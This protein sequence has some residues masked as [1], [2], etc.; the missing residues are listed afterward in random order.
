MILHKLPENMV[1]QL[2]SNLNQRGVDC[3]YEEFN[4]VQDFWMKNLHAT[5]PEI[6][7]PNTALEYISK[8]TSMPRAKLGC[9]DSGLCLIGCPNSG[10]NSLDQN[11]YKE[12][13]SLGVDFY[14]DTHA[15]IG[16]DDNENI[17]VECLGVKSRVRFKLKPKYSIFLAA[18]PVNSPRVLSKLFPY[19]K[20]IGNNLRLNLGPSIALLYPSGVENY[21]K[22]KMGMEYFGDDG[23][24]FA[25]QSLPRELALARLWPFSL[26]PLSDF[27]ELSKISLWT[28]SIPSSGHGILDFKKSKSRIGKFFLTISDRDKILQSIRILQSIGQELGAL[29]DIPLFFN[30]NGSSAMTPSITSP[31]QINGLSL[32]SSHIFG[33][34]SKIGPFFWRDGVNY[35]KTDAS[36]I[37]EIICVDS[38]VI[39]FATGVNPI[40]T[41][42]STS[43][44][45][46]R[47]VIRSVVS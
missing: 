31:H 15:E 30:K 47:K 10:K 36:K 20:E 4:Q 37:P 32:G 45:I 1:N 38:S 21:E 17:L 22:M 12:L 26:N 33:T 43:T 14:F 28:S 46:S 2:I 42:L 35:V 18:G 23:V 7:Y 13:K 29:R 24:K 40:I 41:I 25:T 5:S 34:I 8:I 44:M 11:L 16:Y 9:K 3:E 6:L 27:S 19:N 39:P